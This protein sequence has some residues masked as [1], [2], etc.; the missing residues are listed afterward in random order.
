[1]VAGAIRSG[2]KQTAAHESFRCSFSGEFA[3]EGARFAGSCPFVFCGKLVGYFCDDDLRR[4]LEAIPIA[5]QQIGQ[6][7]RANRISSRASF[8]ATP[9][10]QLGT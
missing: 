6:L 2:K 4:L 7:N 9:I 5:R 3:F 1:V 10:L 8:S